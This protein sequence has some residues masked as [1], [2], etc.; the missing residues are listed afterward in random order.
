MTNGFHPKKS[1]AVTNRA[2]KNRRRRQ[3]PKPKTP[4]NGEEK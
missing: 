1:V 4:A 3:K 2:R